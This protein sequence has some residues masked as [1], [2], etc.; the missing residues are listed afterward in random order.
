MRAERDLRRLNFLFAR[1][2]SPRGVEMVRKHTYNFAPVWKIYTEIKKF[3][4]PD[5]GPPRGIIA[6]FCFALNPGRLKCVQQ[7][8]AKLDGYP[9][10]PDP[11]LS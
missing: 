5:N 6:P 7:G 8:K 3:V 11:R 1:R 2:P 10:P 4:P 9:V